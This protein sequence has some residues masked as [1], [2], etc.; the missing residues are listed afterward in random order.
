MLYS[1]CEIASL[2]KMR[3]KNKADCCG[4]GLNCVKKN[5]ITAVIG[6]TQSIWN[7]L[8]NKCS[9]QQINELRDM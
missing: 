4:Y 6:K 8:R 5:E 7:V 9:V 2:E 1:L 3:C